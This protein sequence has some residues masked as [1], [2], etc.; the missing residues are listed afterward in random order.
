VNICPIAVIDFEASALDPASYPIEVGIA[1]FSMPGTAVHGWST[2]I[3]PEPEWSKLGWDPDAQKIHGITQR[4]LLEGMAPKDAADVLDT[5]LAPIG[6]AWCDGGHYDELWLHMLYEAAGRRPAFTLHHL[7]EL[8]A[9]VPDWT[10]RYRDC[11]MQAKAPHRPQKGR[12]RPRPPPRGSARRVL[13]A[14]TA[15]IDVVPPTDCAEC[16]PVIR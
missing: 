1:S 5:L 6:V 9:T 8:L 2:L 4:N 15:T 10:G 16:K 13:Q 11:I 7:P 14:L 3:R 12:E